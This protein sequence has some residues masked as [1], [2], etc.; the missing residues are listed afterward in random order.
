ME[1]EA[2]LDVNVAT[3]ERDM[4]TAVTSP[5][6]TPIAFY[7]MVVSSS[8]PT[9]ISMYSIPVSSAHLPPSSTP[10]LSR[11]VNCNALF[12]NPAITS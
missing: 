5:K 12:L 3:P 1:M 11:V 8:T 10:D 7:T 2:A 6:P 9:P 4:A